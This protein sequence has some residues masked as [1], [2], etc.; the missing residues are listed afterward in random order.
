[1]RG[2]LAGG[3]ASPVVHRGNIYVSYPLPAGRIHEHSFEKTDTK[4]P[5]R[6]KWALDAD[7]VLACI[8]GVTGL[9]RWRVVKTGTGVGQVTGDQYWGSPCAA[10]GRVFF[11]GSGGMVYALDAETGETLW[12]YETRD[13]AKARAVKD[14][15]AGN[16]NKTLYHNLYQIHTALSTAGGIVAVSDGNL[17]GLNAADGKRAWS[18]HG[19]QRR[20]MPVRWVHKGEE[21]FITG[22]GQCVRPQDGEIL[23]RLPFNAFNTQTPTVNENYVLGVADAGNKQQ[24]ATVMLCGISPSGFTNL[25][26]SKISENGNIG[27]TTPVIAGDSVYVL[28]WE[29]RKIHRFDIKTGKE[30]E[31]TGGKEDPDGHRTEY[32]FC[33]GQNRIVCGMGFVYMDAT[34]GQ[35][36][37]LNSSRHKPGLAA[38]YLPDCNHPIITDGRLIYRSANAVYCYDLRVVSGD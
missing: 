8:D 3:Y 26:T 12:E 14:G 17:I 37:I 24:P 15:W 38:P 11:L 5:L 23:W 36:K 4:H 19:T 20:A 6:E 21:Y 1:L 30:M 34:P 18:I 7:D 27:L 10:D 31:K 13:V 22:K 16:T 2:C 33:M 25:W 32:Y 28:V 9:T 29:T 35:M